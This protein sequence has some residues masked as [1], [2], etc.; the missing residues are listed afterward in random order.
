MNNQS[1]LQTFR[2]TFE[3]RSSQ[4]QTIMHHNSMNHFVECMIYICYFDVMFLIAYADSSVNVLSH[5]KRW[6]SILVYN[7]QLNKIQ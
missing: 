2:H 6:G 4:T 5:N 3:Q 1:G 7:K